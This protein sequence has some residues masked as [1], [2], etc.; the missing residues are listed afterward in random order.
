MKKGNK[1]SLVEAKE[2]QL[3]LGT[4]AEAEAF[5]A[6]T[7]TKGEFTGERLFLK[8]PEKYK[9]VL[10][11][12]AAGVGQIRMAEILSISPNTV[13]AVQ[14]REGRPIDI[15]KEK[16]SKLCMHAAGLAVEGIVEDLS[17][18]TRRKKVSAKDK[19]I[20][21]GVMAEKG[22]L[23]AGEATGRIEVIDGTPGHDDFNSYLSG[24]KSAATHSG[25]GTPE[26]KGEA[27]TAALA[28]APEVLDVV[29]SDTE[30]DVKSDKHQ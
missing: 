3:L 20:I 27:V 26:Q 4:D 15:E 10:A 7:E 21:A 2:N 6:G 16:L 17:D 22:L 28:A 30:S 23:T 1:H 18:P 11:L 29:D 14:E 5:F 13:R 24:L 25:A 12:T 9:L 19:A 8:H